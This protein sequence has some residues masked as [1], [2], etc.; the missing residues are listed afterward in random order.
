MDPPFRTPLPNVVQPFSLAGVARTALIGANDFR[1][2]PVT[3]ADLVE[4]CDLYLNVAEPALGEEPGAERMRRTLNRLAYE[5]FGHQVSAMENI[6]RTL[7]LFEDHA[8]A[9]P[10]APT[11]S[12]WADR[13]GVPLPQFVQ[14]G[15]AMHTAAIANRGRVQRTLMLADN[16]RPIFQPLAA[17]AALAL[18]DGWFAAPPDELRADGLRDER[19]RLEKW[20]PN[21]LVPRP[22]VST[23]GGYVMPVP[24]FVLD[25][26]TATGLYFIGVELFGSAFPDSL[27]RMFESYVGAQLGLLRHATVL[28]EIVYGRSNER[29]V[30]FFLITPECIVLVEVK[31]AR[32][33]RATREGD[34]SSDD[35]TNKKVGRAFEQIERT[36]QLIRSA[37]PALGEIPQDRPLRG[38]VVTLEPFHLVNT[39][40]YEDVLSRPS[41]PTAVASA[42]ELEGVVATLEGAK[43]VG[44]RLLHALEDADHPSPPALGRAAADL[45][46]L[47][48]PFLE[49]AWD[50][51][52]KP[53]ADAGIV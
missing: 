32:P 37:H 30:D 52:T 4:M 13:L 34:A 50:R 6:G 12:D 45:P 31:A 21:P 7:A 25:R 24:H 48:N 14:I 49:A 10:H 33:I 35:D 39:F 17:D 2:T 20:S 22:M 51:F 42:H 19:R 27:G 26:I 3:D 53:W 8:K 46:S 36:T 28:P 41:I 11:A 1:T 40:V 44:V 47:P 29:T 16:V 15:F 38:L 43:D 9:T 18:V 5:Q 23:A